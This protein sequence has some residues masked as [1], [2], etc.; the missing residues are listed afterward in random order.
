MTGCI[1]RVLPGVFLLLFSAGAFGEDLLSIDIWCEV[2]PM[3]FSPDA[4]NAPHEAA[5]YRALFEEARLI[6]SGM[7]YGYEF[8]YV[9]LD[10]SR[11]VREYLSVKPI[12]EIAPGDPNLRYVSG[13][14]TDGRL[15]GRFTYAMGKHQI[16]RRESWQT[17][18]V[19]AA[20]GKGE[21]KLWAGAEGK[22]TSREQAIK[23]AVRNYLRPR[24]FNKPREIKG[25]VIFLESPLLTVQAGNYISTVKV[26]INVKE[27]IP[28]SVF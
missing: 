4:D 18:T 22:K 15:Y 6:F 9:P 8:D 10:K 23:E 28:Y 5:A 24:V 14:V 3:S 2:Q 1:G 12:A 25:E 13:E 17:I 27:I 21:G 7:I 16:A 20:D 19:P 26:K 11:G